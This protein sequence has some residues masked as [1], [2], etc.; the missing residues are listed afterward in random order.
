[1]TIFVGR[2]PE[3]AAPARSSAGGVDAPTLKARLVRLWPL[4]M[5][6]LGV[7]LTAVWSAGLFML[8]LGLVFVL[9]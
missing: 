3:M 9:V 6:A 2:A 5:V 8:L 4:A 7:L 1:M